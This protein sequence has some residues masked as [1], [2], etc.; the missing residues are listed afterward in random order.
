MCVCVEGGGC[1]RSWNEWAAHVGDWGGSWS[2]SRPSLC[3]ESVPVWL[4]PQFP[5]LLNIG[6]ETAVVVAG[7]V[8]PRELV[9]LCCLV[10]EREVRL[11]YSSLR[12]T[13]N[14]TAPGVHTGT[15]RQGTRGHFWSTWAPCLRHLHVWSN[16]CSEHIRSMFRYQVSPPCKHIK[17]TPNCHYL[18]W[19][20]TSPL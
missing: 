2:P 6:P 20:L 14:P 10:L 13:P 5:P 11:G 17:P 16:L 4:L 7:W 19:E 15:G 12:F 3:I 9:L 18:P 1:P 8:G